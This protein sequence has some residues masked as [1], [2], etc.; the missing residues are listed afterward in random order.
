MTFPGSGLA[1]YHFTITR[2]ETR[3]AGKIA[4]AKHASY[5]CRFAAPSTGT[6]ALGLWVGPGHQRTSPEGHPEVCGPRR[7]RASAHGH[8]C[9][10]AAGEPLSQP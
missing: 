2:T 8:L 9:R 1:L 3:K 5:L 10:P 4:A 6:Q 7:A